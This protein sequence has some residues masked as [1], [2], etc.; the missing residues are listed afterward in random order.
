MTLGQALVVGGLDFHLMRML[1]LFGLARIV[2]RK[3]L[4][5]I[6]VHPIDGVF[7]A[8]LLASSFLYLL[9]DPD[10]VN[11]TGRLGYAYNALGVYLLIRTSVRNVEDI[12]TV[13]TASAVFI[14]PLAVLFAV[15]GLTGRNPFAALGGVPLPS[16]VRDGRIRA[17]GP[18]LHPIL[19]GTFGATA[20][21]LFVGLWVYNR[22]KRLL[23]TLA[24]AAAII[25]V[26][27]SASSGALSA[28]GVSVAALIFWR[29]RTLT[30][31]VRWG[32]VAG[33][34]MLAAVMKEPVWFVI[35]RL[36]DVTGGGGWYRSALI[37]AAVRHLDEW[38]LAG[39][40]YTAHWM[41][42]GI[43]ADTNSADLVNEFVLQGVHGGILTLLLFIWMLVK[44]F[45]TV[46]AEAHGID[47]PLGR[48]FL[49]WS[50][51]CALLTHVASFFS[52]SYFDQITIFWYLHIGMVAALAARP[53]VV[54][55]GP[56]RAPRP[57]RRRARVPLQA[58]T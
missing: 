24:V 13:V 57:S 49:A 52:V 37:D 38:W 11:I 26:G 44:C 9:V 5:G 10:R 6:E 47:N 58:R 8:W 25:I 33:L 14:V 51:G 7:V 55:E 45:K 48:R 42:T 32:L 17:Q 12:L 16:E 20:L 15:E 36:S 1:I 31:A 28:L 23:A 22:R 19:A 39:T 50:L 46:G 35:A 56:L 3:E 41:P 29:W 18:F 40:G 34:L 2:V 54:T 21:P 53:Q 4:S 43:L 27:A 30:R